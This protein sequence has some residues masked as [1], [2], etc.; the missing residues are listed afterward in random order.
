MSRMLGSAGRA[1]DAL[2]G[3]THDLLS[4]SESQIRFAIKHL[5]APQDEPSGHRH[6]ELSVSRGAI[7]TLVGI[8]TANDSRTASAMMRSTPSKSSRPCPR[9]AGVT[10]AVAASRVR[11]LTAPQL[12]YILTATSTYPRC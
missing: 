5:N 6:L 10:T 7:T 12:V 3:N 9:R 2:H 4:I 1:R 8:G 11:I